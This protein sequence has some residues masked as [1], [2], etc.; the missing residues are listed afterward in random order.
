MNILKFSVIISINFVGIIF[1]QNFLFPGDSPLADPTE[2]YNPKP[3]PVFPKLKL[4]INPD[5]CSKKYNTFNIPPN[6]DKFDPSNLDKY[7]EQL[8]LYPTLVYA[9]GYL[10]K[11]SGGGY[12]PTTSDSLTKT[13]ITFNSVA[14]LWNSKFNNYTFPKVPDALCSNSVVI[15]W[16]AY[17]TDYFQSLSFMPL[18]ANVIGDKLYEMSQNATN[19]L[20]FS[21]F[22]FVGFSLGAHM[23]GMI[24]RRINY[25]VGKVVIPR[26]TGLDPAG[27]IIEFPIIRDFYPRLDKD[28]GN[29]Y[30]FF[31][32]LLK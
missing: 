1:G 9:F 10:D 28:C 30:F 15:D 5:L 17:N 13:F 29:F 24:A 3:D 26:V 31:V 11:P 12:N 16:S 7:T 2:R 32:F 25:R 6:S 22:H 8:K 14:Q 19:T 23:V 18:I 27:P 4:Y 20:D 21:K